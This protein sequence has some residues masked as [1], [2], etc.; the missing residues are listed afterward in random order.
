[1]PHDITCP[2]WRPLRRRCKPGQSRIPGAVCREFGDCTRFAP[3][4]ARG[5]VVSPKRSSVRDIRVD[6][7]KPQSSRD[8]QGA[9]ACHGVSHAPS[10]S[11]LCLAVSCTPGFLRL[12]GIWANRL[13]FMSRT[14]NGQAP[15]PPPMLNS[16]EYPFVSGFLCA[17]CRL[18]ASRSTRP[19]FAGAGH[20]RRDSPSWSGRR[21]R[22]CGRRC[23]IGMRRL[24]IIDLLTGHRGMGIRGMICL[25]AL[26]QQFHWGIF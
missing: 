7:E 19:A 13:T 8:R 26:D 18:R 24:S 6:G 14:Q 9:H 2:R 21:R 10:R 4:Y 17:Y 11:R 25:L 16:R 22:V 23:G 1:M 12:A 20:V 3:A 5:F 15:T